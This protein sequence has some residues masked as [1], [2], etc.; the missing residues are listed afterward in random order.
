MQADRLRRQTDLMQRNVISHTP[1][2]ASFVSARGKE[3][4]GNDE[5]ADL[6]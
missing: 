6:S 2:G 4:D 1:R 5:W 3:K